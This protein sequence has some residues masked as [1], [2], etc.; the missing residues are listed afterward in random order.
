MLRAPCSFLVVNCQYGCVNANVIAHIG[1]E[2][3]ADLAVDETGNQNCLFAGAAFTAHKA[4]GDAA[5]R[6]KTLFIVNREREEINA[7]SGLLC[8][9]CCNEYGGV[10]ERNDASAVCQTCH[11]TDIDL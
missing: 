3:G 4:A 6:I 1:G 10:T 2:E 7:F 5:Y 9:S 11:L 8:H